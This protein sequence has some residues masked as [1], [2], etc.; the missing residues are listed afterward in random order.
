MIDHMGITVSKLSISKAFYSRTL[1]ALGY[2]AS[3]ECLPQADSKLTELG[4]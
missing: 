2:H 3:A 1:G 4:E